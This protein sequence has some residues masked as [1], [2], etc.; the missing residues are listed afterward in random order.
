MEILPLLPGTTKV[1]L[2]LVFS[3]RDQFLKKHKQNKYTKI[4]QVGQ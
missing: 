1:T 4:L 3:I 2:V